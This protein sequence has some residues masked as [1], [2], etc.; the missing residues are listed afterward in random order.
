MIVPQWVIGCGYITLQTLFHLLRLLGRWLGSTILIKL[1]YAKTQLVSQAC[2]IRA[3]QVFGK[4][5]K[6]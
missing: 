1:M 2:H 5:Q 4:K 6:S 3:E